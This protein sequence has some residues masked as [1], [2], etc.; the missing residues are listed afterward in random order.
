MNDKHLCVCGHR[1]DLHVLNNART[2]G[3]CCLRDASAA[4]CKWHAFKIDNLRM[5]EELSKGKR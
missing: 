4:L 1:V 2:E 5:L 3:W